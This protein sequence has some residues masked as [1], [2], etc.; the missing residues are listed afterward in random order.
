LGCFILFNIEPSAGGSVIPEISLESD[1]A[2]SQSDVNYFAWGLMLLGGAILLTSM[3]L[4]IYYTGDISSAFYNS[5]VPE[6]VISSDSL[7]IQTSSL[8][9]SGPLTLSEYEVLQRTLE[10]KALLDNL[11]ISPIGDLWVSP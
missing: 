4:S 11:S 8:G 7:N 9:V 3:A 6:I 10:N 5:G 2:P 1:P